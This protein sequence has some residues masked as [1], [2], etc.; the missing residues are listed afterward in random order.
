MS[1]APFC[2]LRRGFS[3]SFPASCVKFVSRQRHDISRY[4]MEVNRVRPSRRYSPSEANGEGGLKS[5]RSLLSQS[6]RGSVSPGRAENSYRQIALGHSSQLCIQFPFSLRRRN[7]NRTN[8]RETC[9]IKGRKC[10]TRTRGNFSPT[11]REGGRA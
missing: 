5:L 6:V 7:S 4:I 9:R 11:R 1:R 10:A 2:Y 8:Y 3:P